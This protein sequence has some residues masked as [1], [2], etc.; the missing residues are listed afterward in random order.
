MK[1]QIYL[2]STRLINKALNKGIFPAGWY[3]Q[4]TEGSHENQHTTLRL[5]STNFDS[6]KLPAFTYWHEERIID[7]S[8][9]EIAG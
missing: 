4:S 5:E 9:E 3:S 1:T 6:T 7:F 8:T 2:Y